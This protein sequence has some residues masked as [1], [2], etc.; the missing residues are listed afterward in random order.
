[1]LQTLYA[2]R[3][4]TDREA[5]KKQIQSALAKWISELPTGLQLNNADGFHPPHVL[6]LHMQY[7]TTLL[8]LHRPSY[9]LSLEALYY[10]YVFSLFSVLVHFQVA[11]ANRLQSSGK[12]MRITTF[13]CKRQATSRPSVSLLSSMGVILLMMRSASTYEETWGL[14]RAPVFPTYYIFTA[15]ITY[16][17]A[18]ASALC[19]HSQ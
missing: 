18:R 13:A 12:R 9:V 3:P 4:P 8:L 1:M 2:V 5:I 17:D 11:M 19:L 15:G 7:W 14:E 6:V 10:S 16:L